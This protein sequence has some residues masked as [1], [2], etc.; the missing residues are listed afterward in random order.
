[1]FV[2]FN[3]RSTR[4]VRRKSVD[5]FRVVI[6]TESVMQ[7][8]SV[9]LNS[10]DL[11]RVGIVLPQEDRKRVRRMLL[12]GESGSFRDFFPEAEKTLREEGFLEPPATD[13]RVIFYSRISSRCVL[14]G[15]EY[16]YSFLY[17]K[18]SSYDLVE[19]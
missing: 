15:I 2:S 17:L 7:G 12:S 5:R 18:F 3:F 13:S 10:S 11:L 9:L 19:R 4:Q 14:V 8:A 16:S 6:I 1:M